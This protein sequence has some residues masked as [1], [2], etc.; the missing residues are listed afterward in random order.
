MANKYRLE[1]V[2]DSSFENIADLYLMLKEFSVEVFK[3]KAEKNIEVV[4]FIKAHNAGV[5]MVFSG[6]KAIGFT[7]FMVNRYFGLRQAVVA[8]SYMYLRPKYRKTRA[9]HLIAIQ[10]G[11]VAEALGLP[12]EHYYAADSESQ[13]FIGRMKGELIYNAY[14][15]PLEVVSKEI[16]KLQEKVKVEV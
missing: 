1:L 15:Y 9:M 12:L 13:H 3:E 14:E 8:N 4:Q 11:K 7:S 5:Y 16:E 2:N 6:D 10:S